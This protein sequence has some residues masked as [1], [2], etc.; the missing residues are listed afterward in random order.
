[1]S[2]SN[3]RSPAEL[4][5][6][7][8]LPHPISATLQRVRVATEAS[9]R[10][11]LLV[12]AGEVT[13]R[14]VACLALADYLRGPSAHKVDAA[15]EDL[16]HP[17]LGKWEAALRLAIAALGS[18]SEPAPFCRELIPWYFN[19]RGK[20]SEAQRRIKQ[21]VEFRN[22][23]SHGRTP[24]GR[25]SGLAPMK[26]GAEL[27][28][29]IV[30]TLGWLSRYRIVHVIKPTP[31]GD[32]QFEGHIQMFVGRDLH[33]AAERYRWQGRLED[34]GVYLLDPG[35]TATLDLRDFALVQEQ[36]HLEQDALYVLSQRSSRWLEF[37]HDATRDTTRKTHDPNKTEAPR[38][39]WRLREVVDVDG[40]L[41]H[42]EPPSPRTPTSVNRYRVLGELGRGGMAVVYK[43]QD[44]RNGSLVA[45]KVIH[46]DLS[47][48]T[49]FYKRFLRE[50][51]TS[52]EMQHPGFLRLLDVG[53]TDEG[54]LYM[55]NELATGG[56]LGARRGQRSDASEVTC[57]A[58]DALAAL[59]YL[60]DQGI[61]HRDIKPDNLLLD[62]DGR[63]RIS[64]LGVA[65][66]RDDIRLTRSLERLGSAAYAAPEMFGD[67]DITPAADIFSLGLA[68]DELL[69]GRRRPENP[70][71]GLQGALGTLIRDMTRR[72]PSSRPAAAE[73]LAVLKG[74]GT[75]TTEIPAL[76]EELEADG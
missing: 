44:P 70:G 4:T 7:D 31:V 18:R 17:T 21:F 61:V 1:M 73:A 24:L 32:M 28:R 74:S 12:N 19:K 50:M 59:A 49:W 55:V 46:E 6:L 9:L 66:A 67:Q 47:R 26:T 15:F 54:R 34:G 16:R 72:N 48:D 63:C 13:L 3:P 29:R 14:L 45:V 20:P 11:Q 41:S 76:V 5:I 51:K 75:T 38:Q 53:K 71:H 37:K 60:H 10:T 57:W 68:L 27:V 62:A 43:A 36:I 33:P 22:D 65:L 25:S 64:D 52:R 40:L 58:I 39:E 2:S 8:Q 56:D 69:C 30:G 23:R 42:T 35:A